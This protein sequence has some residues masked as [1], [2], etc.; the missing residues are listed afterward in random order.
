MYITKMANL[1]LLQILYGILTISTKLANGLKWQ[2]VKQGKL[3]VAKI[4]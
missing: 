2:R 3:T 1:H 4:E